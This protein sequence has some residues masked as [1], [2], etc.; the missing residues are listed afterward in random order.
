M[1]NTKKNP[2]VPANRPILEF[3]SRINNRKGLSGHEE[4]DYQKCKKCNEVYDFKL[5]HFFD[6]DGNI[7]FY[8]IFE[9]IRHI[10][11]K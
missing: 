8:R 2:K 4:L 1:A 3:G 7:F 9:R 10:C 6:A 5:G 11:K